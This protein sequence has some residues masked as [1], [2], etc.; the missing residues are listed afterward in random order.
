MYIATALLIAITL[1]IIHLF[2]R[3]IVQ[4][5]AVADS[6]VHVVTQP[7]S[8]VVVDRLKEQR[9]AHLAVSE[10]NKALDEHNKLARR[11]E[12]MRNKTSPQGQAIAGRLHQSALALRNLRGSISQR[13]PGV[14]F[15]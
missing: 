15:G 8:E 3:R 2:R 14:K 10:Y 12:L 6:I 13:H 5:A 1:L 4:N 7:P 9:E 11:Y